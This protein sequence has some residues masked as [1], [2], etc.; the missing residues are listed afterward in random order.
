VADRE[1]YDRKNRLSPSNRRISI[2]LTW[3][4]ARP[5]FTG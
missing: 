3:S 5:D 1:P 2:T 4:D